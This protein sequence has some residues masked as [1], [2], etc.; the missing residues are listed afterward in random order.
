MFINKLII[1]ISFKAQLSVNICL[2]CNIWRT[3]VGLA[4]KNGYIVM[5]ND[6]FDDLF[7]QSQTMFTRIFKN[8]K[9]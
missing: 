2:F 1:N 9:R 8:Y 3:K 7:N 4:I 5:Q 6:K